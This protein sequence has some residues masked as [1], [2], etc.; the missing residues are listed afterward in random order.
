MT[1][2]GK[3]KLPTSSH[4]MHIIDQVGELVDLLKVVGPFQSIIGVLV[5]D[6]ILLKYKK[7]NGKEDN[8]WMVL[9]SEKDAIWERLKGHFTFPPSYD[10]QKV[11]ERARHIMGTTFKNF[12]GEMN[13]LVQQGK[14]PDFDRVYQAKG[15]IG[16]FQAI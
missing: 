12:K 16:G 6:F 3:T 11:K 7:W 13:K 14:Q 2:R 15:L 1:K 8:E 5:R 10:V 4:P 9:E